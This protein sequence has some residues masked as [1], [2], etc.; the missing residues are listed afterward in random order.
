V[1]KAAEPP[2]PCRTFARKAAASPTATSFKGFS[3]NY[4]EHYKNNDHLHGNHSE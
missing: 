2:F 4:K 3:R 1:R